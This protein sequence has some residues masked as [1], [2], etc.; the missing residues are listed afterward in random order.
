MGLSVPALCVTKRNKSD[1]ITTNK[2]TITARMIRVFACSLNPV[3]VPGGVLA[4]TGGTCETCCTPPV[5]GVVCIKG[6][7]GAGG[8]EGAIFC[9]GGIT[10]KFAIFLGGCNVGGG[11]ALGA[12][13]DVPVIGAPACA[14][15]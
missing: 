6:L 1:P 12:A 11:E 7:G 2:T 13:L 10:G 8:L 14:L 9:T 4:V 15:I 3:D 5:E